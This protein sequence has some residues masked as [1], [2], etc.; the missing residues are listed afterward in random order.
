MTR[1]T[2]TQQSNILLLQEMRG[3]GAKAPAKKKGEAKKTDEPKK[4]FP[5][6]FRER[7]VQVGLLASILFCI[8][9]LNM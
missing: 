9:V 7:K 4:K 8:P 3:G 2:G 6:D 1:E 5:V